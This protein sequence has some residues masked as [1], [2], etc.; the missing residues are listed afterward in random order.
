VYLAEERA[1][2]KNYAIKAKKKEIKELS[3]IC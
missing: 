3:Y 2:K 1:T